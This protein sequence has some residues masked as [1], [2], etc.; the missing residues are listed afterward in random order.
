MEITKNEC[1]FVF[2]LPP[3][4]HDVGKHRSIIGESIMS[5]YTY[6]SLF[7]DCLETLQELAKQMHYW[8]SDF[9]GTERQEIKN[10]VTFP[11]EMSTSGQAVFVGTLC[12]DH[13]FHNL[14][15]VAR[16]S[17]TWK[18]LQMMIFAQRPNEN[19]LR[20]GPEV[21]ISSGNVTPFLFFCR[22]GPRKL[23]SSIEII[24]SGV[25]LTFP[26]WGW[27]RPEVPRIRPPPWGGSE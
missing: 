17:T 25:I 9:W 11:E 22:S 1:V 8:L 2:V 16:F 20:E 24:R 7:L 3:R 23:E 5:I 14:P 6:Y 15:S 10:G 4:F 27:G 13:H 18:V 12:K 21:A 26:I 19:G